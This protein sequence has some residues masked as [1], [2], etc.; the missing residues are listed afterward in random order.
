MK[1]KNAMGPVLAI[2]GLYMSLPSINQETLLNI[3]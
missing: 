2:M 3:E 1:L